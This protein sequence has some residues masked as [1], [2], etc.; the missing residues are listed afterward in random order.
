MAT[1]VIGPL[2]WHEG[3]SV[4]HRDHESQPDASIVAI[5]VQLAVH[6]PVEPSSTPSLL[7]V[8]V[9]PPNAFIDSN[10]SGRGLINGSRSPPFC[11]VASPTPLLI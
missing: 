5:P 8:H 6:R 4:P 9:L 3:E 10:G 2:H 7:F 11:S 1:L